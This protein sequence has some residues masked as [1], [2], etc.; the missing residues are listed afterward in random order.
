[1]ICMPLKPPRNPTKHYWMSLLLRRTW[2]AI[3]IS[4]AFQ[5]PSSS[6]LIFTP[7]IVTL[8]NRYLPAAIKIDRYPLITNLAS[9]LMPLPITLSWKLILKKLRDKDI[10]Q[11]ASA[12]CNKDR[13]ISFDHKLSTFSNATINYIINEIDL[14]KV[15]GWGFA[16]NKS[17]KDCNFCWKGVPDV[18]YSKRFFNNNMVYYLYW[19][20]IA[21][22]KIK[23]CLGER[24]LLV[25]IRTFH[26]VCN[27]YSYPEYLYF[28]QKTCSYA[29]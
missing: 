2:L 20:I 29:I 12:S 9:S 27:I 4:F 10:K 24:T 6:P 1:M 14:K 18:L 23:L 28:Y 25:K 13:A 21:L 3:N 22:S 17:H 26:I 8:N 15:Q 16:G 11:L 19:C 7:R 5:R